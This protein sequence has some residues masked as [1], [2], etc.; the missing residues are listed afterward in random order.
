M[1]H[2]RQ[3]DAHDDERERLRPSESS[4]AAGDEADDSDE[5]DGH[6]D[7]ALEHWTTLPTDEDAVIAPESPY[8]RSKMMV[9]MMLADAAAAHDLTYVARGA[10]LE[11]LRR[12]VAAQLADQGEQEREA[13]HDRVGTSRVGVVLLLT[14]FRGHDDSHVGPTGLEPMTPA[15]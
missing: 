4:G 11:A 9:E 14:L 15:V 12:F 2:E 8:G 5:G 3:R 1:R 10:H 6:W 13:K 7:R